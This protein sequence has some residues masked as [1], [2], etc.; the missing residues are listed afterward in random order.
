MNHNHGTNFFRD[1]N[2][3]AEVYLNIIQ[4][5]TAL[6]QKDKRDAVFQQDNAQVHAAK[7]TTSF[8]AEFFGE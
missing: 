4:Q 2:Y 8:L 5:F 1:N 6:L 3:T 7:N